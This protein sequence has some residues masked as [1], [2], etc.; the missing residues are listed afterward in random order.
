MRLPG[1][2]VAKASLD[3]S[4]LIPPNRSR[5][6]AFSALFFGLPFAC[7]GL[8]AGWFLSSRGIPTLGIGIILGFLILL[9]VG[10][11]LFTGLSAGA[12]GVQLGDQGITV[13]GQSIYPRLVIPA[14][15]TWDELGPPEMT[16]PLGTEVFFPGP[17]DD[18]SMDADQARVVLRDPRYPWRGRI[19]ADVVRRLRLDR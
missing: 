11:V 16:G 7:V 4:R 12:W 18:V 3:R 9:T 5:L 14:S 17:S 13:F 1:R 19:P 10:L 15:A 2:T 8:F 6:L